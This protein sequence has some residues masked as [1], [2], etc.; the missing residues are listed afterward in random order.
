MCESSVFVQTGDKREKVM[1]DGILIK[2]KGNDVIAV[3]LFGERK[4]FEN[5]SIVEIDMDRHQIIIQKR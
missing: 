3:S 2:Q 4:D 5:S 1:D